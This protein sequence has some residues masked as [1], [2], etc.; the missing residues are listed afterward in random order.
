MSEMG[1]K[2]AQ[3][4]NWKVKNKRGEKKD[5]IKKRRV[6][7]QINIDMCERFKKQGG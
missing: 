2:R 4:T 1:E 6:C 3:K 5:R 7:A